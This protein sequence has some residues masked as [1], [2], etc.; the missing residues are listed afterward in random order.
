MV[1]IQP[2]QR[3][4]EQKITHL[5][6]I[7]IEDQRT[8]I[9]LFAQARVCM[10]IEM[11]AI[12]VAQPILIPGE[13]RWHPI[14]QHADAMLMTIINEVHE[15]LRR[16]VTAGRREVTSDLVSPGAVE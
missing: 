9:R 5:I 13:M 15:V 7:K 1:D 8:P 16:A 10:L 4:G 3:I 12:K 14:H 11:G 6:A 2:E